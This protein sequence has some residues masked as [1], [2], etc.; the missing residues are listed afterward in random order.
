MRIAVCLSGQPRTWRIAAPSIKEFFNKSIVDN[1]Q[2]EVD[3]FIHTWSNN[4]W[5]EPGGGWTNSIEIEDDIRTTFSPK[6]MLFQNQPSHD[7]NIGFSSLFRSM[8]LANVLKSQYELEHNFEYDCVVK[9]R[10]DVAFAPNTGFVIHK[11]E[12]MVAYCSDNIFTIGYEFFQRNFSDIFFWSDSSTMDI[13]IDAWRWRQ[14]QGD[15]RETLEMANRI[16]PGAS[17]YQNMVSH[18]VHPMHSLVRFD[19]VIVRKQ[20]LDRNLDIMND[21]REI[22]KIHHE[23]YVT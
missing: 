3:Y 6:M 5:R 23:Y 9:S 2:A 18:G 1:K 11:V 13:A 19:A 16:G 22:K 10:L 4:S 17:L 12:P 14:S 20:A 21:W 8:S 7:K 15:G